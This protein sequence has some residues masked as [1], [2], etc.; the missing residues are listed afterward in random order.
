MYTFII[1]F[2]NYLVTNLHSKLCSFS[3]TSIKSEYHS[4]IV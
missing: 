2:T 1:P 3:K 4:D